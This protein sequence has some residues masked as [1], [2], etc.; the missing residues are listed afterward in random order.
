MSCLRDTS[1]LQGWGCSKEDREG[2][3]KSRRRRKEKEEK[4]KFPYLQPSGIIQSAE[5]L[6]AFPLHKILHRCSE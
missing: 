4:K 3:R 6:T 5:I 1:T 2:S